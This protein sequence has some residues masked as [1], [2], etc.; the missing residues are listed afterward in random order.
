MIRSW[1]NLTFDDGSYVDISRSAAHS[2]SIAWFVV[3]ALIDCDWVWDILYQLFIEIFIEFFV[4]GLEL[5]TTA[6]VEAFIFT[7]VIKTC[8]VLVIGFI[9]LLLLTAIYVSSI[10]RIISLRRN[11]TL[12]EFT[13]LRKSPLHN[14]SFLDNL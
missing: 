14:L 3:I 2:S 11:F 12:F 9:A 10:L 4:S 5:R 6:I 13:D 1:V 7:T 8:S